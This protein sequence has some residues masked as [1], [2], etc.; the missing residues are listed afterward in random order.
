[1]IR[2][3]KICA[4]VLLIFEALKCTLVLLLLTFIL[5]ILIPLELIILFI[6][7]S[8]SSF[9]EVLI[10]EK[11]REIEALKTIKESLE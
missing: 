2:F 6:S 9:S 8:F 11:D 3:L 4:G 5:I 1:M 10:K 7:K